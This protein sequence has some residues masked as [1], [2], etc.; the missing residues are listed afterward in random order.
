MSTLH[1]AE[2]QAREA[3]AQWIAASDAYAASPSRAPELIGFDHEMILRIA[4]A[5]QVDP[6]PGET[7]VSSSALA[8]TRL[9]LGASCSLNPLLTDEAKRN[10]F[11]E[12]AKVAGE[13]LIELYRQRS[14]LS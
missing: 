14:R 2:T 3:V 8:W 1:N 4:E 9:M 6:L 11:A 7:M 12:T 5:F 13:N 10:M